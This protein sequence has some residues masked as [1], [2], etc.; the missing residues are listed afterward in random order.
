[1]YH[2]RFG[3]WLAI[4]LISGIG[5]WNEQKKYAKLIAYITVPMV[6]MYAVLLNLTG[7]NNFGY[8]KI[9]ILLSLH[10]SFMLSLFDLDTHAPGTLIEAGLAF[11][12]IFCVGYS[13]YLQI[14]A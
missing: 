12:S 11:F 8:A 5:A 1:M 10:I 13:Y 7:W 6:V 9:G 2:V 3:L 4:V 14:V